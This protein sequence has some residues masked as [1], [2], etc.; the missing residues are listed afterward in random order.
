MAVIADVFDVLLID[1]NGDVIGSS[2]LQDANIEVQVKENEVRGGKGNMLLG[3]LHSDRDINISLTDVNFRY[4]WIA[5]QLGQDIKT[6]AGVAYAMP[7]WYT[8]QADVD[9][10]TSGNQ[11]GIVLDNAPLDATSLVIYNANGEKITGFTLSGNKVNLSAATPSVVAGDEVEVRTYQ[12]ATPAETQEIEIDNSVFAKG[13]KAILETVEVD[14]AT[15]QVTHKL[16]YEFY[17][18]L[19]TG[20]LKIST[21]SERQAHTQEFSLRVVKPKSSTVVGAI[22]RIPIA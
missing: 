15:E 21:A 1:E 10:A 7:K 6:G 3:V 16:Q 9:D 17:N 5:K 22:K 19:P 4:D 13:V 18:T 12:Y 20:N 8:V 2:T 14:E 11:L